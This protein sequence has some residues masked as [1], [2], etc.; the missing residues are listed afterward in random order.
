MENE[1]WLNLSL[2]EVVTLQ[3]GFDLPSASREKKGTIPVVSSSGVSGFHSEAKAQAPGVVTGRYGSVG[4]VF[5]LMEAFW[6][7]NTTLF[8]VDFK[9]NHALFVYY[10]LQS[11]N[12]KKIQ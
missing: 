10:L 7:L 5:F 3:R 6:P 8:V 1:K 2:G 12:F 11:L 4:E 9:G